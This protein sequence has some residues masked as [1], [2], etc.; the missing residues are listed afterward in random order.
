M[1][2]DG[3]RRENNMEALEGIQGTQGDIRVAQREHGSTRTRIK[4]KMT[5][6][7]Y[8][9]LQTCIRNKPLTIE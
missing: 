1:D 6:K 5:G 4:I 2:L 3:M 8:Q 7:Q 9:M